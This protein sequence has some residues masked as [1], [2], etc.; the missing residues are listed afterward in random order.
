MPQC[1]PD[2]FPQ[3]SGATQHS[4]QQLSSFISTQLSTS[5]EYFVG[6]EILRIG[7]NMPLIFEQVPLNFH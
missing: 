1:V 6:T 2:N 5:E 4:K 7:H 3:C